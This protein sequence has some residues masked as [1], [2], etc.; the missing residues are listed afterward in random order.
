VS[1]WTRFRV[2]SFRTAASAG[3]GE[4][5]R[6]LVLVAGRLSVVPVR[7]FRLAPRVKLNSVWSVARIAG[8]IVSD[9]DALWLVDELRM[10]GRADDVTA[11]W[12][13]EAGIASG[14]AVEELTPAQELAVLLVLAYAPSVSLSILRRKLASDCL[15]RQE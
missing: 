15:D 2:A 6:R 14:E 1:A 13:I 11:A 7:S 5:R 3:P 12:A 4:T 9:S 8:V 10:V